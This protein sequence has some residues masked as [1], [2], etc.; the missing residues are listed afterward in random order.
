MLHT[1]RCNILVYLNIRVSIPWPHFTQCY[2]NLS[3]K[4]IINVDKIS[5]EFKAFNIQMNYLID[6]SLI[7]SNWK[8]IHKWLLFFLSHICMINWTKLIFYDS[9]LINEITWKQI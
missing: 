7:S 4:R 8:H 5:Q 1:L 9:H 2:F 6:A 3:L